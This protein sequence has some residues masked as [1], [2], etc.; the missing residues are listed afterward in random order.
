MF[1]ITVEVVII[2]LVMLVSNLK[3][4]TL[5]IKRGREEILNE[6]RKIADSTDDV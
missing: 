4:Y 5:G 2:L 3:S 6:T 1:T